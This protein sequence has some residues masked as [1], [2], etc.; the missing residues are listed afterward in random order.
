MLRSS[1]N[2]LNV[3]GCNIPFFNM[4]AQH[5]P[6]HYLSGFP[7]QIPI[8]IFFESGIPRAWY[9]N[10]TDGTIA[11][12]EAR[13]FC[14]D[15]IWH[16][17]VRQTVNPSPQ[18]RRQNGRSAR[19]GGGSPSLAS[20]QH[21]RDDSTTA[22]KHDGA[23]GR[24]GASSSSPTLSSSEDDLIAVLISVPPPSYESEVSVPTVTHHLTRAMLRQLLF[25]REGGGGGGP[26]SELLRVHRRFLLQQFH[27]PQGWYNSVIRV[28][29]APK[30]AV[31]EALRSSCSLRDT[32]KQPDA[33]GGTFENPNDSI[34]TSM[35]DSV[36]QAVKETCQ[37]IS[38]HLGDVTGGANV[39][40]MLL[41]F[42]I[43][44]NREL[45]LLYPGSIRVHVQSIL[46][47][48]VA[49]RTSP[50][51]IPLSLDGD[52]NN[53]NNAS[54]FS[55]TPPP[56]DTL[57][58]PL[59]PSHRLPTN[60]PSRVA[61]LAKMSSSMASLD[62]CSSIYQHP[63][64]EKE[65]VAV[66]PPF[67]NVW[68]EVSSGAELKRKTELERVLSPKHRRPA[69]TVAV[70]RS[71]PETKS[72]ALRMS[73]QQRL[74]PLPSRRLFQSH[75]DE[76][77]EQHRSAK[78]SHDDSEPRERE[79]RSPQLI[80]ALQYPAQLLP[81]NERYL[82]HSD[83][84]CGTHPIATTEE[85]YVAA[86]R[87]LGIPIPRGLQ[88]NFGAA[89]AS[90]AGLRSMAMH[91]SPAKLLL[92]RHPAHDEVEPPPPPRP[93]VNDRLQQSPYGGGPHPT[94][95]H[96][97]NHHKARMNHDL[98]L[99]TNLE[100]QSAA[101]PR[102]A[103]SPLDNPALPEARYWE[104]QSENRSH[105]VLGPATALLEE[106]QAGYRFHKN[107][108][109]QNQMSALPAPTT[110]TAHSTYF[111]NEPTS[112]SLEFILR[113]QQRYQKSSVLR[114]GGVRLHP[115]GSTSPQRKMIKSHVGGILR[116]KHAR[117]PRRTVL[118][119]P[120]AQDAERGDHSDRPSNNHQTISSSPPRT[121]VAMP[122]FED[123]SAMEQFIKN[124]SDDQASGIHFPL[125]YMRSDPPG[126]NSA[127]AA[128]ND[129]Y[130]SLL[131]GAQ[132]SWSTPAINEKNK[133]TLRHLRTA[134]NEKVQSQPSHKSS[135]S[136]HK[137]VQ[138]LSDSRQF[139]PNTTTTYD[140][141]AASLRS[142]ES[143][144]HSPLASTIERRQ[145]LEALEDLL[146]CIRGAL[147]KSQPTKHRQTFSSSVES[148]NLDF[149][150]DPSVLP[151]KLVAQAFFPLGAEV[152][153][154]A[155]NS[156]SQPHN[157]AI[158]SPG[159]PTERH[160]NLFP[161]HQE[162]H[163]GVASCVVTLAPPVQQSDLLKAVHICEQNI[164]QYKRRGKMTFQRESIPR[165]SSPATT[166]APQRS[167]SPNLEYLYNFY[168][169]TRLLQHAT[170]T[171]LHDVTTDT[172]IH[173]LMAQ[174]NAE[175]AA[176]TTIE[177]HQISSSPHQTRSAQEVPQGPDAHK[178]KTSPQSHHSRSVADTLPSTDPTT[179]T[180]HAP[181]SGTAS[182]K[183]TIHNLTP[184][185][186]VLDHL[187]APLPPTPPCT[188]HDL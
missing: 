148:T 83:A 17:F 61:S 173:S 142:I 62:Q 123:T 64:A 116:D 23:E 164:K 129:N 154:P 122:P 31:V 187:L 103:P 175:H 141:F 75:R 49:A 20:K 97:G 101:E 87:S 33:R 36:H 180:I 155:V 51:V 72:A 38:M 26:G 76:N 107:D 80:S 45:L 84:I 170:D 161:P 184:P 91:Y 124:M 146:Y 177:S 7:L 8:S 106:Q 37:Y 182:P 105:P 1:I 66:K 48:K 156:S 137:K 34:R 4:L 19:N 43:N 46:P 11:K 136:S 16:A 27:Y 60:S 139:T 86:A 147:P 24:Q 98:R 2:E 115:I 59:S 169:E 94:G 39:A 158:S 69:P 67:L 144:L 58:S 95:A 14:A 176:D 183:V 18:Q 85:L 160:I 102:G 88:K 185:L 111:R 120:L 53:N 25:H 89:P 41:Y 150:F 99:H 165:V 108:Q 28:T 74:S 93:S 9:S 159:T 174:P 181:R 78:Q 131:V 79:L 128:N 35:P 44:A 118:A 126:G 22:T 110:A 157:S 52:N 55:L 162:H 113:N 71:A 138:Q 104:H 82:S 153:L 92:Q 163:V 3:D 42:K 112:P 186:E 168:E 63:R 132:S 54:S 47:K 109:Q 167:T 30:L 114:A 135:H 81:S 15:D 65:T 121:S 50:P 68:H 149:D 140:S 145:A 179:T 171:P 119:S 70:S 130:Y 6:K 57:P 134:S 73:P 188:L 151:P 56:C 117:S 29:W 77:G 32:W 90:T 178:H 143:A 96:K 100:Q 133:Q 21:H 125:S 13:H 166:A 40:G 127:S 172:Q 5:G 12:K 152:K 10:A